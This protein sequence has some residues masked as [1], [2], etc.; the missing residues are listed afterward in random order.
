MFNP[1]R[2]CRYDFPGGEPRTF[3]IYRPITQEEGLILQGVIAEIDKGE[4]NIGRESNDAEGM[5][6]KAKA[7]RTFI[8]GHITQV[9]NLITPDDNITE[10]K[11]IESFLSKIGELQFMDLMNTMRMGLKQF[12]GKA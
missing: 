9:G 3:V 8:A 6:K 1:D 4:V 12:E 10:E 5:R 11:E 2:P 7:Q